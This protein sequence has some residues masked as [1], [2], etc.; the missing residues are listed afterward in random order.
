MTEHKICPQRFAHSWKRDG[1]YVQ[2]LYV[3][4]PGHILYEIRIKNLDDDYYRHLR[5][6]SGST[7]KANGSCG[8]CC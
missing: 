7:K 4:D 6:K 5:R 2:A 8:R 1:D 3:D